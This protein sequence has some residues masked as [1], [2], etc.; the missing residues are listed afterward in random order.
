MVLCGQ[1]SI[2]QGFRVNQTE[3]F[4]VSFSADPKASINEHGLNYLIEAEY[5]GFMYVKVGTE[6]F[7]ALQGGYK[8]AHFA[9]GIN[10]TSGYFE[11]MRY[12]AGIRSA[13]V[14]RD[15]GHG[16]NYGLEAGIQF[17]VTEHI[18]L[19]ARITWD[20]RLEQKIIFG[21]EPEKKFSTFGTIGY[22]WDWRK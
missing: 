12:Y 9:M 13:L 16:V 5:A 2:S 14:F 20:Y 21:W 11:N 17:N 1:L 6:Q 15:G 18:Y 8:D 3:F 4:T 22:R 10:F 7:S 19:G